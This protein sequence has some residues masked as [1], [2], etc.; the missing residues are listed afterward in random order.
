LKWKST[1]NRGASSDSESTRS[2]NSCQQKIFFGILFAVDEP[3][4]I[5]PNVAVVL[6]VGLTGLS[7]EDSAHAG[8]E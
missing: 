8:L 6:L 2:R 5:D 3:S 1:A 4:V 7:P